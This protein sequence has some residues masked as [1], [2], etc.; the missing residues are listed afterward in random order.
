MTFTV[1]FRFSFFT[2]CKNSWACSIITALCEKM[3]DGFRFIAV[4]A[5]AVLML[6]NLM[7]ISV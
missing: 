3:G 7:Q 2:I 4:L 1:G 6:A 5:E